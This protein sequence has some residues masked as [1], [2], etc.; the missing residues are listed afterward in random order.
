MKSYTERND[1]CPQFHSYYCYDECN[2]FGNCP[3][4]ERGEQM[5]EEDSDD[6]RRED[7]SWR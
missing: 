2:W 3:D 5:E 6:D 1:I 4:Q 7:R